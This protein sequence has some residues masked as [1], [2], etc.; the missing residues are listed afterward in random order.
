VALG[1]DYPFPLGEERPGELIRSISELTAEDRAMLLG[2]AARAF[3]G[4]D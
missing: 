1:S 2:G 3:L 4:H